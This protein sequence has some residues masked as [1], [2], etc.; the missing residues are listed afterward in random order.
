MSLII[1]SYFNQAKN[2]VSEIPD[3]VWDDTHIV[4]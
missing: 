3:Q 1:M 2:S 4:I